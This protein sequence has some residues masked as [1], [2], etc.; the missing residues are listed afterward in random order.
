MRKPT[1]QEFQALIHA[2]NDGSFKAILGLLKDWREELRDILER[3]EDP[4]GRGKAQ[5]IKDFLELV[6]NAPASLE[7]IRNQKR[8]TAKKSF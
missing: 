8:Q 3:Q 5:L 6:E 7:A 1:E 2:G 4:V